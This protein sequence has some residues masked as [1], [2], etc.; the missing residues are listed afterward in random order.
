MSP[1]RE[2]VGVVADVKLNG[3]M[4]ETPLQAYLPITQEPSRSLAIVVRTANDAA[5]MAPAVEA[6]VHQID[7]DLALYQMRT[8]DQMLE[9][10]LARQRMSMV[11]FIVFAVVALTLAAVGLY[12][13]MAQGVTERTHE[14]GVRIALGAERRQV[15]G[16]V[17]R[18]GLSMTLLGT[19]VGVA[20]AVA[21]SRFIQGLLFGVTATDPIT[22]VVV[23]S[24]L[25]TVATIAC[26][27]PAWRAT[28]VDP[29]QALR[30][31]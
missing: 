15:L 28:R 5:A 26:Y 22:F 30:A 24:M 2:V 8:M 6:A 21:L 11:V 29:T 14:I 1:W 16:L 19:V 23:I 4:V 13:V 17:I 18:Q 3:V 20:G 10:S 7:K 31:E 12:G 27:V 25:L 9:S